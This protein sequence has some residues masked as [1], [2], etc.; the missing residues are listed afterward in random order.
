MI[1]TLHLY[2]G[3][4]FHVRGDWEWAKEEFQQ[5]LGI[6]RQLQMQSVLAPFLLEIGR[7]YAGH[8]DR[9]EA[10]L[11]FKETVQVA[12]STHNRNIIEQATSEL[13]KL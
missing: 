4:M 11:I 9:T 10:Q 3:F 13:E 2:R 8:G 1:G 6:I 5:S 12:E 7:I